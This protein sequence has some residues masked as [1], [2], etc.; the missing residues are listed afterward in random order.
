M[1]F[2]SV[3]LWLLVLA[4][5][6]LFGL[7]AGVVTREKRKKSKVITFKVTLLAMAGIA[8]WLAALAWVVSMGRC[9]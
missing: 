8:C 4:T 5:L 9:W 7:A 6:V 3:F 1:T 2:W